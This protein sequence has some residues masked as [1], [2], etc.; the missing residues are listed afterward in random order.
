MLKKCVTLTTSAPSDSPSNDPTSAPSDAPSTSPSSLPKKFR[1]NYENLEG[2]KF[3]NNGKGKSCQ[4]FVCDTTQDN[5]KKCNK[6]DENKNQRKVKV[7]CPQQ[8][9]KDCVTSFPST[10]PTVPRGDCDNKEGY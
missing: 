3:Y 1:G 6:K 2:Y 7:V 9:D 8:C 4:K 10:S 5:K